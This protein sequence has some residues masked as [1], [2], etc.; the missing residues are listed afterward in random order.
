[1]AVKQLKTGLVSSIKPGMNLPEWPDV[2]TSFFGKVTAENETCRP[3][4]SAARFTCY[5]QISRSPVCSKRTGG[6]I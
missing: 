2:M 3:P 1:M 5:Q 4:E 6:A